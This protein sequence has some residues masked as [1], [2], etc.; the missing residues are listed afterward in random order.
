MTIHRIQVTFDFNDDALTITRVSGETVVATLFEA[1]NIDG[2]WTVFNNEDGS[3]VGTR[4]QR[5]QITMFMHAML[6]D[7]AS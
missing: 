2:M 3:V 1:K 6:I 5:E 7:L 4:S